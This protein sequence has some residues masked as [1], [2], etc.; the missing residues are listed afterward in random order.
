M[1]VGYLVGLTVVRLAITGEGSVDA[2][3]AVVD[4]VAGKLA[5]A[6]A[7]SRQGVGRCLNTVLYL[8]ASREVKQTAPNLKMDLIEHPSPIILVITHVSWVPSTL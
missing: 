8:H 4:L 2:A 7:V 1:P 3:W 5:D 6:I